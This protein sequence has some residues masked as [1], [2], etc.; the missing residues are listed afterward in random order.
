MLQMRST[1]TVRRLTWST[2]F[3][4]GVILLF[5]CRSFAQG[6]FGDPVVITRSVEF[7]QS[8]YAADFDGDGDMDVLSASQ[9][10]HKI[11]WYENIDGLGTFGEQRVIKLEASA[12]FA[13]AADLD[14]DGDMDVLSASISD[15]TGGASVRWFEN[16]DGQ[17]N[18]GPQRKIE[19]EPGGVAAVHAEDLDGDG[20]M[21]VLAGSPVTVWYENT[22]GLGNFGERRGIGF[23]GAR[24]LHTADL[25]GD[26]DM[27]VLAAS[28]YLIT[29]HPN[30][31]EVTS[32]SPT[33]QSVK[34][35]LLFPNYPNPFNPET[36]IIYELPRASAV[37]LEI[38]NV[39][40]QKIVTLVHSNQPAGSY[41]VRWQG[42][43]ASGQP[44]SSG[45]YLYQLQAGQF[46]D[47]KKMLFLR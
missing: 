14:G 29:W 8:V 46:V 25:D 28:T 27:D 40:G 12:Q 45:V 7:G 23:I 11:A 41:S 33:I 42:K 5:H 2:H 16:M 31:S 4:L 22:D 36:T 20:D 38:L 21:D 9:N 34:E 13:F 32:V 39:I 3:F 43:D 18:F 1:W 44:V 19:T 24:H 26:G 10:D 30:L 6:M 15:T 47:A 35:F 37:K 17:G